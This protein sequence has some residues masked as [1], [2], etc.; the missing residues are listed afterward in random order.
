MRKNLR[1]TIDATPAVQGSAGIGRYVRELLRAFTGMGRSEQVEVFCVMKGGHKSGEEAL[2]HLATH[3]LSLGNKP[4]RFLVLATHL[5]RISMHRPCGLSSRL[6]HATDHL[7]PYLAGIGKVFTLHDLTV[8]ICPETHS[9]LN[10]W[11]SNAMV[12]RFMN[13]ADAI[14]AVSESTKRDAIRIA[15]IPGEKIT[16]I[17]HGVNERFRPVPDTERLEVRAR[18]G[19]PEHFLLTVGT[20]EPRKNLGMLLDVVKALGEEGKD[21]KLVV[22]GKKGWRSQPFFDQL[23]SL[24]LGGQVMLTGSI[25]ENDLPA[26]YSAAD[27]FLF[28]SL[29][30]GFGLPVLE[31]MACGV[32]VLCSDQSSLPEVAGDA[33]VLLPP[34]DMHAWMQTVKAL[35]SNEALL[36]ELAEKGLRRSQAFTW[37]KTAQLTWEVYERVNEGCR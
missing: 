23:R 16:V 29:Y 35:L 34:H 12:P 5:L 6:F 26:L 21:V 31:A 24:G 17:P 32:P 11:F 13:Y 8:S 19:L 20:I 1:V 15:S 2:P 28:P 33:A 4:W 14:I 37:E 10:R 22:A 18:Y 25:P 30:E 27:L 3:A 7:L 36:A 9:P